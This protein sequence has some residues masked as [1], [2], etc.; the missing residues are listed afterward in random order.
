MFVC[1]VGQQGKRNELTCNPL[2][3]VG[4]PFFRDLASRPWTL[5]LLI[6]SR[7]YWEGK[8]MRKTR[9]KSGKTSS[10]KKEL[11]TLSHRFRASELSLL[12]T[13]YLSFIV[14]KFNLKFRYYKWFMDSFEAI[15]LCLELVV[16]QP[17]RVTQNRLVKPEAIQS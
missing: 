2:Q 14:S 17:N 1:L 10:K 4:I 15:L 16:G 11:L 5:L 9:N 3:R 7:W 8:R 12:N 6:P 13:E